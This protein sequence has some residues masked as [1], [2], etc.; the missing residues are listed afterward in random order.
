MLRAYPVSGKELNNMRKKKDVWS[1][2][3]EIKKYEE[4]RR[5]TEKQL[6]ALN[7]QRIDSE[8]DEIIA[9]VRGLTGKDG[10]VMDT[11]SSL[12]T[13]TH[14]QQRQYILNKTNESEVDIDD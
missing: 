8:N 1:I 2:R 5:E 3:D 11:I 13:M 7:A 4:K 6:R 14:E 12:K 10:D 9:F